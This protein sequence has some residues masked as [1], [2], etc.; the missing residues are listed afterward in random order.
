MNKLNKLYKYILEALGCKI[1]NDFSIVMVNSGKE[2]EVKV[3]N[4]KTYL[5]TN[6]AMNTVDL[7]R[8]FFHPACESITSKETEMDKVLRKLI[9]SCV[10]FN[11]KPIAGVLLKV[12][13]KPGKGL[14]SKLIERL[15]GLKGLSAEINAEII[16]LVGRISM[17]TEYEGVDTRIISYT[18]MRGGKT[19]NDEHIYYRCI[20]SFPF[21]SEITRTINQNSGLD[22]NATIIF[23]DNRYKLK[24]LKVVQS[25]F[26]I[27]IPYVED[28]A[29]GEATALNPVAARMSAMLRCFANIA[30]EIN[31][32]MSKFRKEFDAIGMYGIETSWVEQ[33]DDLPELAGLVPPLDYN[34][35]NTA[36]KTQDPSQD[37]NYNLFNVMVDRQQ[38]QQSIPYNTF[39]T[40][41]T[42]QV[43][44]APQTPP[45]IE[46]E[47][48]IG[49]TTLQNGLFEFRFQNGPTIRVV[50]TD[51]RGNKITETIVGANGQQQN[52]GWANPWQQNNGWGAMNQNGNWF[53]QPMG[54][55]PA[56][57]VVQ[58]PNGTFVPVFTMAPQNQGTD[59]TQPQ[60]IQPVNN[61]GFVG[62]NQMTG[63]SSNFD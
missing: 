22:D 62:S 63:V 45:R 15:S 4:K 50:C 25:V 10:Y 1:K 39:N 18:L 6:E 9:T 30:S 31:G 55:Q 52:N 29:R 7:E 14:S 35:Y 5:A 34:N 41:Q 44:G 20:P 33:L 13:N 42:Q 2:Y 26:E 23:N 32:T 60:Q 53:Q 17:L 49:M 57:Q 54:P 47:T 38:P 51:D 24:T 56:S 58:L 8:A 12:A 59:Y 40:Q 16:D 48:Y 19:D 43:K 61:A 28:P 27:V 3:D 46:G 11:F 36:G 21:Y 37:Q